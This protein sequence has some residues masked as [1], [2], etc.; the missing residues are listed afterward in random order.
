MR[1]SI[2]LWQSLNFS[3]FWLWFKINLKIHMHCQIVSFNFCDFWSENQIVWSFN[4]QQI[5]SWQFWIQA[6]NLAKN[7]L[8][9]IQSKRIRI[10]Y[11]D[12]WVSGIHF[13]VSGVKNW[14]ARQL[15]RV[16]T[17]LNDSL[18][19]HFKYGALLT[20]ASWKPKVVMTTTHVSCQMTFSTNYLHL[21]YAKVF[22]YSRAFGVPLFKGF[23]RGC[24]VW[25]FKK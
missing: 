10:I 12:R 19:V 9:L 1:W 11:L 25:V 21:F 20:S 7:K 24:S 16:E 6:C 3:K 8:D 2:D 13:A 15:R 22:T 4:F 14:S 18:L 23:R 5:V 17:S